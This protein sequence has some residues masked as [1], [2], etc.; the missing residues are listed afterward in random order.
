MLSFITQSLILLPSQALLATTFQLPSKQADKFILVS[1][2]EDKMRQEFLESMHQLI[3]MGYNLAGTPGTAEYYTQLG[4]KI[5]SL[6]K[7]TDESVDMLPED[8]VIAWIR[9]K[10]IDLV[11][12]IPEGTSRTDEVTGGYLM[13]R[14]AVDF[15]ASL[16][17]NMKCAVLFCDALHRNRPLPCK[18][19]EDFIGVSA[20][21]YER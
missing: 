6:D 17:T 19:A 3:E 21:G 10:R 18:S 9:D 7:P 16:L 12:N 5:I 15:G 20:Q 8:G 14:A 2:A 1:I 13:R 4:I 11:I